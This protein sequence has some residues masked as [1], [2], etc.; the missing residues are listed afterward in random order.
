MKRWHVVVT[1]P[2]REAFAADNL[3][4]GRF[5]RGPSRRHN[6]SLL[7]LKVGDVVGAAERVSAIEV[8]DPTFEELDV[9]NRRRNDGG[10]RYTVVRRLFPGYL[11]VR[12]D[13]MADAH[14]WR[15]LRTPGVRGMFCIGGVP[16]ALPAQGLDDIN[17][18][19]AE[20]GANS[21]EAAVPEGY[22]KGDTVEVV[23]DPSWWGHRGR[24]AAA[25][26]AKGRVEVLLSLLGT[27]RR[28]MTSVDKIRPVL[29]QPGE[30]V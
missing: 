16:A 19:L 7:D 13:A 15:I 14:W 24:L 17:R 5:D 9:S 28:L 30:S 26:D 27:E 11:L 23:A 22:R 4:D 25:P 2:Q 18:T 8:W 21:G 10:K 6:G 3:K 20:K 1:E 29:T 12:F